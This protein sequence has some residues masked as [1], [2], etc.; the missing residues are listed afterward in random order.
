MRFRTMFLHLRLNEQNIYLL[1]KPFNEIYRRVRQSEL[2]FRT[3]YC[4]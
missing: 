2:L 1:I 3:K 4:K